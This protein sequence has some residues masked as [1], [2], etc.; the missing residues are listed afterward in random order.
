MRTSTP[1]DDDYATCVKTFVWLRVM[2]ESLEPDK[3]TIAIGI[4]PTRTQFRGAVSLNAALKR[5][6]KYSGWFLESTGHV[7]SRDTRRHLDWLLDKLQGKETYLA[8]LRDQGNLVDICCRWDS[9][10]QGGPTLDSVHLVRLGALGIEF[11]FD[12]YFVGKES[13]A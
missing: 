6:A 11:W 4:Q 8:Q 7:N 2:S 3:V 1:Y 12:V 5:P 13:D 10:G 9:Q